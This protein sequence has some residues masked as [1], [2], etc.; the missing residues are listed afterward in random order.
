M[1]MLSF[2]RLS[3]LVALVLGLVF[4]WANAVPKVTSGDIFGGADCGCKWLLNF[5]CT[6]VYRC[7]NKLTNCNMTGSLPWDCKEKTKTCSGTGSNCSS[8]HEK[9][10]E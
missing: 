6:D 10:C 1:K 8:Y 2:S 7:F 4:A 9:E 3:V 5:D